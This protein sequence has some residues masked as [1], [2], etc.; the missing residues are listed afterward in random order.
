[1]DIISITARYDEKPPTYAVLSG[2]MSSLRELAALA[3]GC[4][5]RCLL[6]SEEPAYPWAGYLKTIVVRD[7]SG[8]IRFERSGDSLVIVGDQVS[9]EGMAKRIEDFVASKERYGRISPAP[10]A[11]LDLAS[12]FVSKTPGELIIEI[13]YGAVE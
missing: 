10:H 4:G 5:T 2:T 9:R 8:L 3:R 7:D 13:G 6:S 1:M 11:H 12:S